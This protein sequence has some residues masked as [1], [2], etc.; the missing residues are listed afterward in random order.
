MVV[1]VGLLTGTGCSEATGRVGTGIGDPWLASLGPPL[2]TNPG[3]LVLPVVAVV[4]LLGGTRAASVIGS[5]MFLSLAPSSQSVSLGF[6]LDCLAV[7]VPAPSPSRDSLLES[8][9]EP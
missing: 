7:V 2:A 8:E 6:C 3:W 9:L 4:P 1:V 5:L